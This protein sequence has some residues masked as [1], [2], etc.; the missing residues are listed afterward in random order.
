MPGG[1][2]SCWKFH[3][4][5]PETLKPVNVICFKELALTLIS[6]LFSPFACPEGLL[7]GAGIVEWMVAQEI[8]S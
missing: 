2:L 4:K 7:P 1:R 6:F 5:R 8:P 3:P